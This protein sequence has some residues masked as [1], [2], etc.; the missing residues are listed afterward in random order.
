[1]ASPAVTTE[2]TVPAAASADE[3]RG[4]AGPP[5]T[6]AAAAEVGAAGAGYTPQ[7]QTDIKKLNKIIKV[8]CWRTAVPL[9]PA[10]SSRLQLQIWN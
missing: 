9:S 10:L 7:Q 2:A 4:A 5:A 3:D 6:T 8:S 1:M